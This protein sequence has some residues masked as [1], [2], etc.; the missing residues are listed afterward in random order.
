MNK[1]YQAITFFTAF[2]LFQGCGATHA[3]FVE[4]N[5][6][7]VGKN[8][9]QLIEQ[10]GYPDS[11]YILPNKNRVYV[12]KKMRTYSSVSTPTVV[13]FDRNLPSTTSYREN[14]LI[15]AYNYEIS[16]EVCKTFFEADTKGIIVKWRA[17]GNRCVSR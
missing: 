1:I 6:S 7:W 3:K 13:A 9:G 17:R 11:N 15:V 16:E 8:V 4:K 10:M 12:Y 5:N 2:A 14:S